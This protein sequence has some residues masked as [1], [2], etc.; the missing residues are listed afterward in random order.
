VSSATDA[1]LDSA[2]RAL[3][4]GKKFVFRTSEH[5]VSSVSDVASADNTSRTPEMGKKLFFCP[6]CDYKGDS[7][8]AMKEHCVSSHR[9]TWQGDG[10]PLRDIL[11]EQAFCARLRKQRLDSRQQKRKAPYQKSVCNPTTKCVSELQ[12]DSQ[13]HQS[14]EKSS[15]SEE[16]GN[17]GKTDPDTSTSIQPAT[18]ATL[19]TTA[20]SSAGDISAGDA[21]FI[22]S[23]TLSSSTSTEQSVLPLSSTTAVSPDVITTSLSITTET[24]GVYL[25]SAESESQ[26]VSSDMEIDEDSATDQL[27]PELIVTTSLS[28][29]VTTA[30]VASVLDVTV[31][32]V[33]VPLHTHQSGLPISGQSVAT[34]AP[35]SVPAFILPNVMFAPPPVIAVQP[36]PRLIAAPLCERPL[37]PP[38]QCLVLP[39]GTVRL[40]C[41]PGIMPPPVREQ[42]TSVPGPLP[43]QLPRVFSVPPP[44]MVCHTSRPDVPVNRTP[45][46]PQGQFPVGLPPAPPVV[47]HVPRPETLVNST[48]VQPQGQFPR[49][50]PAASHVVVCHVPRPQL[51]TNPATLQQP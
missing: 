6:N 21:A 23:V 12:D 15:K 16:P 22:S 20:D 36:A 5:T 45:V 9:A 11:V 37:A 24:Q 42:L 19:F 48:H 18:T 38:D 30:G 33:P 25:T 17:H 41:P 13:Q 43:G 28:A 26:D 44:V 8:L 10:K 31:S 14:V 51:A 46:Q 47:C 50:L 49:G 4:T 32:Q 2:S 1:S 3:E 29:D 39:P 40:P 27:S 7:V 34:P 35:P